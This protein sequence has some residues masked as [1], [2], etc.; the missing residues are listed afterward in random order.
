MSYIKSLVGFTAF[1]FL[2]LAPS[3]DFAQI[4]SDTCKCVS[5]SLDSIKIF[6]SKGRAKSSVLK[7]TEKGDATV[8]TNEIVV[9]NDNDAPNQD[10]G[11]VDI[12]ISRLL[13]KIFPDLLWILFWILLF[14]IL[15]SHIHS[16]CKGIILRMRQGSRF[17]FGAFEIDSI[18]VSNSSGTSNP[19]FEVT[20][21]D[22]QRTWGHSR[23]KIYA[24]SHGVMLVHRIMKSNEPDQIY[25][26]IMY[27]IPH[28][29]STLF[30]V[31]SVQYFFGEH[32][33]SKIYESFDRANGFPIATSAYK[34][35][36]CY[37]K[38]NFSDGE[39]AIVHRY[40]DFELGD[41]APFSID[42]D[43][44]KSNKK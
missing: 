4:N 36:L 8:F 10:G 27:V 26:L 3:L 12:P 24:Q 7:T 16:F 35:F 34:P 1:L 17:K 18:S 21:D 22:N 33:G 11:G 13:E 19:L 15:R 37:A 29:K 43:E 9:S 25:D 41:V 38:L 39:S 30:G 6:K 14:W 23:D 31:K 5:K 28:S 40:I 20:K 44:G 42:S 32:W 2:F